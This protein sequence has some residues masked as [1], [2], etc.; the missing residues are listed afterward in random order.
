MINNYIKFWDN[1]SEN[2]KNEILKN[3]KI[4]TFKKNQI[5]DT[6]K[7]DGFYI[8]KKGLLNVFVITD[9]QKEIS[10]FKIREYDFCLFSSKCLLN[11]FEYE[12]LIEAD[13]ETD[14]Y[15]IPNKIFENLIDSSLH[16][17]KYINEILIMRFSD[18]IWVIDQIINNKLLNR[19]SGYLYKIYEQY[20]NSN[21][22]ITHDKIAKDL[23]THREVITRVINYLVEQEVILQGRGKIK[24][25]NIKKLMS[26]I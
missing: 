8:I 22:F 7:H 19:I 26:F 3:S 17:N 24:I 14:V 23:N 9:N 4:L 11:K 25:K 2:E 6:S 1:L 18:S 12:I 5:I 20:N 16:L 15:F 21:I 13:E 10:L